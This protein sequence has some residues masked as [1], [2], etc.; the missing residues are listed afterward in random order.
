M[1]SSG[2]GGRRPTVLAI[3]SQGGHWLELLRLS[4]AWTGYNVVYV[5]TTDRGR[6]EG[7][8]ELPEE[9]RCIAVP[10]ANQWT[11]LKLI[12]QALAVALAVIRLRPDV[13]V[14]TGAA[15]GYFALRVGR[16]IG[17]RTIWVDSIANAE[18]LSMSG[19]MAGRHADLWLTQWEHLVGRDG[20]EYSGCVM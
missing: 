18:E 7:L 13:I 5:T 8:P 11:K 2:P 6:R 12:R 3:A 4:P 19:R 20:P 16:L 10:E 9:V 17:A 14:S 15:P 1:T